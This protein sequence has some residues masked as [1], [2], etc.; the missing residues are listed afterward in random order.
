[1]AEPQA[2]YTAHQALFHPWLS[3]HKL[4]DVP[5][6]MEEMF[7][8]WKTGQ[9]LALYVK[10]IMCLASMSQKRPTPEYVQHCKRISI[11][12]AKVVQHVNRL[13]GREQAFEKEFYDQLFQQYQDEIAELK[14]KSGRNAQHTNTS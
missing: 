2:R 11:E 1:M 7:I 14:K 9:K 12:H 4:D 13:Q 8:G 6:T 10:A 3:E 5:L